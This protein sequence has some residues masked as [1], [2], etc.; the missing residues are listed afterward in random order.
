[1]RTHGIR[2]NSVF[3]ANGGFFIVHRDVIDT[4]YTLASEFW[5]ACKAEGFAFNDEP[6]LAYVAQMLCANPYEHTLRA[7]ADV[8]ASDWTGFFAD[9]LPD[10]QPWW[11]TDYFTEEKFPVNPAIVHAMRSK[12]AL[13]AGC[14]PDNRPARGV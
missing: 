2:G 5:H 6:L 14:V 8:W 11:F 3:N 10:G 1:M 7:T 9:R 13:I 4:A 12:S